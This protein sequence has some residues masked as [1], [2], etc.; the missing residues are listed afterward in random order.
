MSG[1]WLIILPSYLSPLHESITLISQ[2]LMKKGNTMIQSYGSWKSPISAKMVAAASLRF[3]DI[4][5]DGEEIYWLESRPAEKGRN[6]IIRY[7]EEKGIEE[8]LLAPYNARSRVHEYGGGAFTVHRGVIYFTNF[9]DNQVYRLIPGV[10]PTPLTN[11]PGMR[12]ADLHI[13]AR[14]KRLVMVREDHTH[15]EQQPVN[16]MVELPLEPGQT[17]RVLLSGNDFYSNARISPDGSRMCWLTWNHPQ[18]PWDGTEL[19]VAELD[20]GGKVQHP[21]KIAGGKSESV[22]QPQWSTDGVL[23]FVSDRSGWWNLYR[24]MGECIEPVLE[25][26]AEF[27]LPQWVFGMSTYDFL[28][29]N[30]VVACYTSDGVW[31]LGEIDTRQNQLIPI[32]SDY[33]YLSQ[34]TAIPGGAILIGASPAEPLSVLRYDA[35]SN[36]FRVLRRS[37]EAAI[38]EQYLSVPKA[39]TFPTDDGT[40]VYGFYYPPKNDDATPPEDEKPPLIVILHGGP[41]AATDVRLNLKIQFWTSRGFAVLDVNY[42]GSTGYGRHYRELLTEQW[43]IADVSDCVSGARFLVEQGQ[44]DAGRL[45]IR[46]GSAGGYT[47]LAALAFHELF[48][49]GACYYGVSDLEILAKDTHK[50]ESRYLDNLIGPYPQMK[51]RYR[52]RSPIYAVDKISA[53]VIF[54]QGLEDRVVPPEQTES[55]VAAFRKR[56]IPVAYASYPEEGHGFRNAENVAHSLNSEWYF[57]SRIFSFD[58]PEGIAPVRIEGMK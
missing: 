52:E 22:F 41:T 3:G 26:E 33:T 16:T 5:T 2:Y 36:R 51:E 10:E 13:D 58:L 30:R 31:R 49:A 8:L 46:G 21:R 55:M 19:W 37:M 28:S 44:V 43:G 6:T 29:E 24:R 25:M 23:Y 9:E 17:S 20:E 14:R 54:F 11:E 42:R 57:Y 50:F 34:V 40:P 45:I 12:F 38:A 18:M 56:G 27:G 53:P 35:H 47:V 15:S 48:S 7:T 1:G 39:I 32:S 4:C